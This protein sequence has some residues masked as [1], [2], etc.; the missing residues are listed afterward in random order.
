MAMGEVFSVA[1]NDYGVLR[2]EIERMGLA[3]E[4][5]GEIVGC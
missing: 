5:K 1:E 3:T 2:V 4:R